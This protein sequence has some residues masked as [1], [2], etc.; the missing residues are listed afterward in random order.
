MKNTN[1]IITG[2]I[3]FIC[4][5]I[6]QVFDLKQEI[7]S[8]NHS[9]PQLNVPGGFSIYDQ[10][11]GSSNQDGYW[12]YKDNEKILYFFYYDQEAKKIIKIQR[13]IYAEE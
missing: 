13:D 5:L 7:R 10:S 3:L 6:F 2:L 11:L 1:L 4:F 12:L 9:H 8:A